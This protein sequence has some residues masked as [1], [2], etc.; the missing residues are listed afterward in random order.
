M[1]DTVPNRTQTLPSRSVESREGAQRRKQAFPKERLARLTVPRDHQGNPAGEAAGTR[2]PASIKR[3]LLIIWRCP[4]LTTLLPVSP[5]LLTLVVLAAPSP[6]VSTPLSCAAWRQ[7]LSAFFFP[8]VPSSS[9][10]PY[11]RLTRSQLLKRKPQPQTTSY[12]T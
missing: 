2:G 11:N 8:A 9:P 4:F 12:L 7:P 10:V 6:F 5:Q 3:R 1:G